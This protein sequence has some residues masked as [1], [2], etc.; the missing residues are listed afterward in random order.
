MSAELLRY[1]SESPPAEHGGF[2]P[3]IVQAATWATWRIGELEA[4][5]AKLR[6]ELAALK[7]LCSHQ[8]K[9]WPKWYA[10]YLTA[11]DQRDQLNTDYAK[12][13]KVID[14]LKEQVEDKC[15][16]SYQDLRDTLAALK[17]QP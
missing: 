1:I 16:M 8:D 12:L 13:S 3:N 6:E 7:E 2:D 5:N 9:D 14:I 11:C 4:D 15:G 17:E 10:I